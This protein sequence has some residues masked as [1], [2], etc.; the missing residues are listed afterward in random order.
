MFF[1]ILVIL[2]L[3]FLTLSQVGLLQKI[4][5]PDKKP[6]KDRVKDRLKDAKRKK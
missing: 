5:D 1:K 6:F 4:E 2:W 3:V